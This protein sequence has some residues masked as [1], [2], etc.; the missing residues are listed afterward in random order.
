MGQLS[1]APIQVISVSQPYEDCATCLPPTT[2]TTTKTPGPGVTTTT[3]VNLELTTTTTAAPTTTTT[4][5]AAETTTT[6]R[7][8]ESIFFDIRS[9][10]DPQLSYTVD[11]FGSGITPVLGEVYYFEL[12][13]Q[14]AGCFSIEP[15]SAQSPTLLV[16][17]SGLYRS[18]ESCKSEHP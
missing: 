4:T 16:L 7:S 3:T 11:F 15:S 12:L 2:T 14:A 8:S 13:G 9:C 6:T 18:C 1:S 10:D 17:V 5:R